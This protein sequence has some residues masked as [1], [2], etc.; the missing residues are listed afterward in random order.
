MLAASASKLS[1]GSSLICL[2]PF[3]AK[4]RKFEASPNFTLTALFPLV[5]IS[6][7]GLAK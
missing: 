5:T 4:S 3:L 6:Q 1:T 2:G 7:Y